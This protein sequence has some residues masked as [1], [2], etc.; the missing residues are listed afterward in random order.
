M[1][2]QLIKMLGYLFAILLILL[3]LLTGCSKHIHE[4]ANTPAPLDEPIEL[5]EFIYSHNGMSTD[6][7]Y[8]PMVRR[9]RMMA[10]V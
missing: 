4:A 3:M 9:R 5:T 2:L 10:L 6:S 8:S 7:C 1:R